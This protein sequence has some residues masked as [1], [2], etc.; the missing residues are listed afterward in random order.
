MVLIETLN[1]KFCHKKYQ[2][3]IHNPINGL[4]VFQNFL[5][6]GLHC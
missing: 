5:H 2:Q 3:E 1:Q 6:Q 4:I